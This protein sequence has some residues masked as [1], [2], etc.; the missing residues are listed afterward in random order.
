VLLSSRSDAGPKALVQTPVKGVGH[1]L[2]AK[3]IKQAIH[4][5]VEMR[6]GLRKEVPYVALIGSGRDVMR[7]AALFKRVMHVCRQTMDHTALREGKSMP[8][9]RASDEQRRHCRGK[10]RSPHGGDHRIGLNTLGER[11]CHDARA[12]TDLRFVYR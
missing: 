2:V 4:A 7:I 8:Q 11:M 12:T 5:R 1:R 9:V 3:A 6:D 10:R